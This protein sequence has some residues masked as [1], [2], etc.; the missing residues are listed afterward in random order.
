MFAVGVG[1]GCLC[2]GMI[3]CRLYCV[4]PEVVFFL[5]GW[6]NIDSV[7]FWIGLG[8]RVCR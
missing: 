4:F 7:G 5:W 2:A 1:L 8:L 3:L 6:Y